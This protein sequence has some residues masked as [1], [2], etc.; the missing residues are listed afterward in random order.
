MIYRVKKNGNTYNTE[1]V[2]DTYLESNDV[3]AENS[4][5][6]KQFKQNRDFYR[7]YSYLIRNINKVNNNQNQ[8]SIKLK[9]IQSFEE[10]I[11][12]YSLFMEATSVINKNDNENYKELLKRL[13]IINSNR[14]PR[15]LKIFLIAYLDDLFE[16]YFSTLSSDQIEEIFKNIFI[17]ANTNYFSLNSE[18]NL[19]EKSNEFKELWFDRLK[20]A[21]QVFLE[22][23]HLCF[24]CKNVKG[25]NCSKIMGIIKTSVELPC[26]DFITDAIQKVVTEEDKT[27]YK[28]YK[29][30]FVDVFIVSGCK[31]FISEKIEEISENMVKQKSYRKFRK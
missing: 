2:I 8:L 17:E 6:Y 21:L 13:E 14:N 28:L 1:R 9:E 19:E 18:Y 15:F 10:L 31:N 29:G 23:K 3:L 25:L 4:I 11:Y 30:E 16:N 12:F 22:S 26:N 24:D 7:V 20:I 5:E 27:V